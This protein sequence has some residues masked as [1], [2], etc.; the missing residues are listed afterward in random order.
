MLSHPIR[1]RHVQRTE[2][3]WDAARRELRVVT[4]PRIPAND[5]HAGH[6]RPEPEVARYRWTG[7]ALRP[8]D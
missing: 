3:H 8:L 1:A 7:N 2:A 4:Q 6:L 5:P